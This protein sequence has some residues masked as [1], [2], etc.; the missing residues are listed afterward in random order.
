[1]SEAIQQ[2]VLATIASHG[3]ISDTRI[4]VLPGQTQPAA[5]SEDQISILGALNSL[6]SREVCIQGFL[7]RI[8]NAYIL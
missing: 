5:S 6:M 1:M 3:K 2:L 4:L 7:Q 8:F